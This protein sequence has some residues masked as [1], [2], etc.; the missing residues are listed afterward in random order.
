M[1]QPLIIENYG[2]YG[3]GSFNDVGR[4]RSV[5]LRRQSLNGINLRAS[6]VITNNDTL[7]HL[8]DYMYDI[9]LYFENKLR[10]YFI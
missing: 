8:T 3:N 9:K 10:I 1:W 6:M 4:V 5:V 7:S 2:T